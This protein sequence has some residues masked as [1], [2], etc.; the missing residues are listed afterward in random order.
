MS[1]KEGLDK[2]GQ[3]GC[4]G[5]Q[6]NAINS[7]DIQ[8]SVAADTREVQQQ[9]EICYGIKG[10]SRNLTGKDKEYQLKILFE[11]R[12][13]LHERMTRKCKLIDDLMYSSSNVTT[14]KKGTD[15]FNDPFKELVFLHK[16]YVGLLL[17]EVVDEEGDWFETVDEVVFTQKHKIYNQIKLKMTINQIEVNQRNHQGEAPR[18]L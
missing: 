6:D 1:I 14:V 12:K 17:P 11:K 8:T 2:V 4:D 5:N 3:E 13:K 10:R 15:Q 9:G 18:K 16:E 7:E